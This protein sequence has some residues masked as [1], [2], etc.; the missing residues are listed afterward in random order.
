M[1]PVYPAPGGN[2][3]SATGADARDFG[4]A[5]G[6]DLTYSTFDLAGPDTIF[7]V[8]GAFDDLRL[9]LDGSSPAD[10]VSFDS[11]NVTG[12]T[13]TYLGS[14]NIALASTTSAVDTRIIVDILSGGSFFNAA[15][16]GLAAGA[17][18]EVTGDFVVN[19]VYEARY[20]GGGAYQPAVDFF[21]AQSTGSCPGG[22][23]RIDYNSGFY[24]QAPVPEP[25]SLALVSLG[26]AGAGFLRRRKR[27]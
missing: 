5:G 7:W 16:L 15:D 6:R 12:T 26:L 3:F 22:C 13:A 27:T 18:L 21:D 23:T 9:S 24:S 1:G 14:S 8:P 20:P 4:R 25:T 19:V 17:A 10:P 11:I 2:D